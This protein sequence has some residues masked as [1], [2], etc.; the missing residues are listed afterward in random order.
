MKTKQLRENL[1][2]TEYNGIIKVH[3][4]FKSWM[5]YAILTDFCEKHKN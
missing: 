5:Q 3:N 4:T 1:I 2:V